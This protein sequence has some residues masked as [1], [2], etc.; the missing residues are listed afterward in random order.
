MSKSVRSFGRS[1][2]RSFP[3]LNNSRGSMDSMDYRKRSMVRL[4]NNAECI[5]HGVEGSALCP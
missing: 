5:A 4:Y 2:V 3:G 1:V